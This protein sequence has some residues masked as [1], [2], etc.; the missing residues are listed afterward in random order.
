MRALAQPISNQ[1]HVPDEPWRRR[2]RMTLLGCDWRGR[3][4]LLTPIRSIHTALARGGTERDGWWRT[5]LIGDAAVVHVPQGTAAKDIV[6]ALPQPTR[7]TFVGLAG[8]L[9]NQPVGTTVDPESAFIAEPSAGKPSQLTFPADLSFHARS[10]PTKSRL[11]GG[12]AATVGCLADSTLLHH[13][14]ASIADYVD[15]E[16]AHLLSAAA[17]A[18]HQMR[19][20]LVISDHNRDGD[21]FTSTPERIAAAV[22]D[23]CQAI[24]ED[25]TGGQ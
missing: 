21:V 14:L 5:S 1:A 15:M 16:S 19:C 13:R 6:F 17:L 10:H 7:I 8:G 3:E 18:G 11:P 2:A 24:Q 9:R 4:M 12:V 23:L 22:D 25:L 20:L